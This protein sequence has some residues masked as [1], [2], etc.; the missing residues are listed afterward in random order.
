MIDRVAR[1]HMII[2]ISVKFNV[3]CEMTELKAEVHGC[4]SY[5]HLRCEK[6]SPLRSKDRNYDR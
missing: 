3:D 4:T 6:M 2:I 1:I 5:P